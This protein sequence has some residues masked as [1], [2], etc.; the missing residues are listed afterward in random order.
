MKELLSREG[1]RFTAHNVDEDE[2]AYDDLIARGFRTIPVTVFGER[3]VKGYDR[4]ALL[5]A[6]AAW[7]ATS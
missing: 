1:V 4:E 6:I 7:R 3:V 5:A 2:R